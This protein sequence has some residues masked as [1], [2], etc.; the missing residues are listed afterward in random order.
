LEDSSLGGW[1]TWNMEM[2]IIMVDRFYVDGDHHV[3]MGCTDS[4]LYVLPF[5]SFYFYM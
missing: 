1:R 4:Q 3:N 5:L 2:E